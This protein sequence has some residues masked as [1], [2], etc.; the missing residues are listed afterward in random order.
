MLRL[1]LFAAAF[2]TAHG[3]S[4]V[5]CHDA[6]TYW[7]YGANVNCSVT[8]YPKNGGMFA[9]DCFWKAH[10][11]KPWHKISRLDAYGWTHFE[12]DRRSKY[13]N[14]SLK[15]SYDNKNH[16]LN[17]SH[18]AVAPGVTFFK[19]HF[20]HIARTRD[21]GPDWKEA[22]WKVT[23][24]PLISLTTG[25]QVKDL[26]VRVTYKNRTDLKPKPKKSPNPMSISVYHEKNSP[27]TPTSNTSI[28]NE[29]GTITYLMTFSVPWA[30]SQGNATV[31]VMVDNHNYKKLFLFRRHST[32]YYAALTVLLV[33]AALV[34]IAYI[35]H[36]H[37]GTLKARLAF[38]YTRD[39]E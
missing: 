39:F 18:S 12:S 16:I 32:R 38:R 29:N 22:T 9:V 2:H 5:S 3:V 13:Y 8:L 15:L 33:L 30:D 34:I 17:A 27:F 20:Y 21:G 28:Q 19:C 31:D 37:R 26:F 24:Y 36:R 4:S 10:E 25:F 6:E 7:N 1:V 11:H 35:V 23:A 14:T